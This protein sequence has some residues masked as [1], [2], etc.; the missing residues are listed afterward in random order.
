MFFILVLQCCF[1]C[2]MVEDKTKYTNNEIDELNV[3]SLQNPK[4]NTKN[5]IPLLVS[6]DFG[7]SW[8][9]ISENLPDDIQVSFIE[10]TN[11]ELVLASDNEGIFLSTEDKSKWKS[12]GA[13]LP[14]KKI[15]ALHIYRDVI[16]AG[17]YQRGIFQTKDEGQTWESL[18]FDLEDVRVQSILHLD[19]YLII[20]CDDG[21]FILDEKTNSWIATNVKTQI[22]SIYEYEENLIAGTSQGTLI[23][24]DKG[25]HWEWIRKEGAVHYTRNIGKRIVELALIGDVVYSDN[26]GESWTQTQYGPREASYVYDIVECGS[27][28]I[29]SNNYGI[30]RSDDSGETWKHIFKTESM[31]FFDFICIDDK[32]YGG[33]RT[34]DE[35]RRK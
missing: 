35:N 13:K 17:V 21:I 11:G 25:K 28:Q 4:S 1:N 8:K 18:N 5:S 27:Y 24:K 2:G 7:K 34:W 16:Y 14:Y 3:F 10:E 29:L 15:N 9:S 19:D 26:W 20:G 31:A 23:S 32:I 33:T 12:I 30:H 22:L 6:D